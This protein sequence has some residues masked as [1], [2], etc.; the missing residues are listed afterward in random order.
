MA[1]VIHKS[2]YVIYNLLKKNKEYRNKRRKGTPLKISSR[3]QRK[4]F[5]MSSNEILSLRDIQASISTSVCRS[6]VNN[7]LNRNLFI[8]NKKLLSKTLLTLQHKTARLNWVKS[9]IKSHVKYNYF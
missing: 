7:Y 8:K 3:E 9:H 5:R 6:T 1:K 4:V 2:Q